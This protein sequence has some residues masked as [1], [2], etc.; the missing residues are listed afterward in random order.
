M[1]WLK[2]LRRIQ[3]EFFKSDKEW[4]KWIAGIIENNKYTTYIQAWD[5]KPGNNYILQ[6]QEAIEKCKR[7]IV[8]LSQNYSEYCQA[9]WATEY[10]YRFSLISIIAHF[11]T[12]LENIKV[13]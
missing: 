6:M 12:N 10:N 4:T 1:S 5:F 11:D 3:K 2:M 13:K 8:V 7:T 9:E